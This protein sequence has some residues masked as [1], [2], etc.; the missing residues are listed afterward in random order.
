MRTPWGKACSRGLHSVCDKGLRGAFAL[1]DRF[2]VRLQRCPVPRIVVVR[3]SQHVRSQ[4]VP[5]EAGLCSKTLKAELASKGPV[6]QTFWS[7]DP[8]R[9]GPSSNGFGSSTAR[10]GTRFQRVWNLDPPQRGPASKW[11]GTSTRLNG[12]QF[13]RVWNPDPVPNG[14]EPRPGSKGF[15]TSTRLNGDLAPK[16]L[17]PRPASKV[18]GT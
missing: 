17:E 7:L 9:W 14:L 13:Q 12:A 11:F 1:L 6:P 10:R 3:R 18:F 2:E 15:G 4:H 16:G 8:P 5:L